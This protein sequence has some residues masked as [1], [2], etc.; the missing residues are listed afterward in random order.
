MK[1]RRHYLALRRAFPH[2]A[3]HEPVEV[4]T[5]QLANVLECTHRNMV[6]LLK[7]MTQEEWLSW[8]PRRGRGNRSTLTFNAPLNGM[9]LLEAQQYVEKQNLQAALDLLQAMDASSTL[10]NQFQEWLT[11]RFGFHSELQGTRRM[12]VL[13]F[14]LPQR[15]HSL[16]PASIHYA[17]ES[18]IVN[19]LF[20]GLVR[21]DAKGE[22]I[23]PHLAHAWEADATR[24][25]W[26]FYLRKGVLFHNGREMIASDVRYSLERL[27]R[28]APQGLYSSI[29]NDIDQIVIV[30]DT[31]VRIELNRR[32]ELFL[33]FL[34]TN[35]ASIV[36]KEACEST[37]TPFALNPIGT[38]PFRLGGKDGGVW[39]L[40]AFA[41][42]FQGRGFLDRVEVWAIDEVGDN[43]ARDANQRNEVTADAQTS[44]KPELQTFQLMHNMRISDMAAEQWQQIRQSGMTCKFLTVNEMK[45]GQLSDGTVRAALDAAID[46][47]RLIEQLSG[48]V[49]RPANSFWHE[50]DEAHE[51]R[52][53]YKQLK[54]QERGEQLE[55]R[56]TLEA[57]IPDQPASAQNESASPANTD[58]HGEPLILATIPQ[59]RTDAELV[60]QLCEAA[61]FPIEICFIAA[62]QFQGNARMS[63]DLMLFAV[64]LDEHRELRLLDLLRSMQQHMLPELHSSVEKDIE[65]LLTEADPRARM[66]RFIAIER[67]LKERNS[68]YFLYRKHLKTAFHPS[69]R[70][71][72]LE[73]LGWVRFR[74]IWHT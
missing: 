24:T 17:G 10:R 45:Q 28:L 57:T 47:V 63:A 4:T 34:T 62:E 36:P 29:Y 50:A 72:S 1:I 12:D 52:E 27:R 69:I 74:D 22:L 64:M 31:T 42:Y 23:L 18:H 51:Q 58:Y 3:D 54:Q 16:D 37:D 67:Q 70:G 61:G 30:N 26:T 60:K 5:E 71:I 66:E 55:Q 13:R 6:T 9:A 40:E 32:N 43:D 19:Q 21:M 46:R 49:I 73:S 2:V 48:D 59:Y 38:G 44:P 15:I 11:G 33:S 14:P 68:L 56:E 8:Q 41:P 35:R 39:M 25:K 53:S 20:D 65:R 7:R